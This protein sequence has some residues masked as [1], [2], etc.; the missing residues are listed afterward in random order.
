MNGI[1]SVAA[2]QSRPLKTLDANL[3]N[4]QELLVEAARRGSRIVVL[5]ENFAY[6][7]QSDLQLIGRREATSSG[8]VRQFLAEQAKHLGMWI[9]GGTIPVIDGSSKPFARSLVYSPRGDCVDYYDKIHLFDADIESAATK[10]SYSESDHYSHGRLIK[11]AMT[12]YCRLGLTVCYDLRFAAL[13]QQLA[14]AKSQIV[15]VPAAF[16]A[17]TG[18]DHWE[19]LLR[20]RA[21]EN[22]FFVIGAN[23]V[24]RDN[25]SRGLW[26]GS[27]IIDPWGTVLASI[28]DGVGVV[29]ADINLT[30]IDQVR[31]R[32]PMHQHKRLNF[33][34]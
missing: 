27:A 2:I 25:C 34:S 22:Q 32:M 12:D 16:T 21:V 20:A 31:L 7:N 23:L 13:Y 17:I 24:D 6:Y 29:T 28:E 4:V 9:V 26:G 33:P 14:L 3:S 1:I 10:S 8:P 5:P 30:M 15:A 18:R 11:T 19:L